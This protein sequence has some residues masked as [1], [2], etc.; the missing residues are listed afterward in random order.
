MWAPGLL[1]P[2]VR[3]LRTTR[4]QF[5]PPCAIDSSATTDVP[6][7][8]PITHEVALRDAAARLRASPRT[9]KAGCGLRS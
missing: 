6:D 7:L 8:K 4:Y 1:T 5:T 9:R 2:L 3:E